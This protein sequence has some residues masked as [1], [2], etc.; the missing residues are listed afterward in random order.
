M[1][2]LSSPKVVAAADSTLRVIVRVYANE[3]ATFSRIRQ[4]IG[5]GFLDPLR[6]FS[7]ACHEELKNHCSER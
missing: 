3:N 6:P 2:V 4:S 5:Q 7:D 1:R